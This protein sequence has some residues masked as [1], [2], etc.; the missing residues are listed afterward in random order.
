MSLKD[1]VQK[2]ESELLK[3]YADVLEFDESVFGDLDNKSPLSLNY[4]DG[5][6]NIDV[7]SVAPAS[8]NQGVGR[9]IVNEIIAF[10]NA[11]NLEIRVDSLVDEFF[12]KMG[13]ENFAD[14]QGFVD[15][16]L[17][18]KLPDTKE[19][20]VMQLLDDLKEKYGQFLDDTASEAGDG[21]G[22]HFD[23]TSGNI[24]DGDEI[25]IEAFYLKP[26]A[27][28][29]GIGKK[30]VNAI[31]KLSDEIDVPITLLDK[32]LESPYG[33]SFWKSMDFDIDD[34]TATALY[35]YGG[36]PS[37]T[38]FA[39]E[40]LQLAPDDP[41]E[42]F[43]DPA[44]ENMTGAMESLSAALPEDL[45]DVDLSDEDK[46]MIEDFRKNKKE[47]EAITNPV[48]SLEDDV[49]EITNDFV[50]KKFAEPVDTADGVIMR[51]NDSN[52]LEVLVIKRKRGPHRGDWALPGGIMDSETLKEFDMA[53]EAYMDNNVDSNNKSHVAFGKTP[54]DGDSK[55]RRYTFT[56]LKEIMEEVGLD[57]S[58]PDVVDTLGGM[59]KSLTP[60]Y[61]R[62]DWDARATQGVSVGGAFV[63]VHNNDWQP[64]AGDDALKAEWK[65]VK[66]IVDGDIK[67]AF[68][69]TEWLTQVLGNRKLLRQ[70]GMTKAFSSF[71]TYN[72]MKLENYVG[73]YTETM[74]K[75]HE[76]NIK[77]KSDITELIQ[78]ANKVRVEKGMPEIPVDKSNIQGTAESIIKNLRLNGP[79][80]PELIL[81]NM[82][83]EE[84]INRMLTDKQINYELSIDDYVQDVFIEEVNK[85]KI[86]DEIVTIDDFT[87]PTSNTKLLDVGALDV[88]LNETGIDNVARQIQQQSIKNVEDQLAFLSRQG[89]NDYQI[90]DELRNVYTEKLLTPKFLKLLKQNIRN[91]QNEKRTSYYA[92]SKIDTILDPSVTQPPKVVIR[93][94]NNRNIFSTFILNNEIQ[95]YLKTEKQ[96]NFLSQVFDNQMM[97]LPPAEF[98][99][100]YGEFDETLSQ[101]SAYVQD[102]K[103]YFQ[104]NHGT[105]GPKQGILNLIAYAT[106]RAKDDPRLGDIAPG[107]KQQRPVFFDNTFSFVDPTLGKGGLIGPLLYTT[108]SPFVGAGY[109]TGSADGH[110]TY[111]LNSVIR[112]DIE[113]FV[114][115]NK[116][117]IKFLSELEEVAKQNGIVIDF[118][119]SDDNWTFT[120]LSD[121]NGNNDTTSANVANIRGSVN[122]ENVL[123]INQSTLPGQG[124]N[125]LQSYWE[126]VLDMFGEDWY[127]NDLKNDGGVVKR[128]NFGLKDNIFF[129]SDLGLPEPKT[130][131][132]LKPEIIPYIV[133]ANKVKAIPGAQDVSTLRNWYRW[134][135]TTDPDFFPNIGHIVGTGSNLPRILSGNLQNNINNEVIQKAWKI[136]KNIPGIF[137]NT[138]QYKN[139]IQVLDNNHHY[140]GI[141]DSIDYQ[142]LSNTLKGIVAIREE[143]YI[144]AAKFLAIEF[145]NGEW[146]PVA[147][148]LAT[149]LDEA[150]S[151]LDFSMDYKNNLV[152]DVDKIL[153]KELKLQDNLLISNFNKEFFDTNRVN[154]VNNY[155]EANNL[156]PIA[157]K[158]NVEDILNSIYSY[159]LGDSGI[160][161]DILDRKIYTLAGQ[162][163]YELAL[164]TG[165]GRV[166]SNPH[167][168]LG[169]ID[170][171]NKLQTNMPKTLEVGVKGWAFMNEDDAEHLYRLGSR[172][173]ENLTDE[174]LLVMS[175]YMNPQTIMDLDISEA[176]LENLDKITKE[177]GIYFGT[178]LDNLAP[179]GTTNLSVRHMMLQ[180]ELHKIHT[181]A[182]VGQVPKEAV[183]P[184][185]NSFLKLLSE[186]PE[187]AR[188]Q[189]FMGAPN[190]VDIINKYTKATMRG[191]GTAL[192]YG[193]KAADKFDKYVL[194]PAALDILASRISGPGS[195]YETIGGA[196]ADTINRYEGEEKDT[197]IEMLYGNKNNPE[198]KNIF[199][200]NIAAPVTEGIEYGKDKF[201]EYV[202]DNNIFG[203]KSIVKF[204]KPKVIEELKEVRDKVGLNDWLYKA[205]RDM[206]VEMIMTD[207]NV[208]YTKENINIYTKAYEDNNPREVDK[209]G[210]ELPDNYDNSWAS[211]IPDNR[212]SRDFRVSE[213]IRTGDRYT[214][215]GGGSGVV[216]E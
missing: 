171:S 86:G 195:Q 27:Q 62:L 1:D 107:L 109:A 98:F 20:Q 104:T 58:D 28:G 82:Q 111:S 163:G 133:A 182:E 61:A 78:A 145:L 140:F 203:I 158:D 174:D 68:G 136:D 124:D 167:W 117:N 3:K 88:P 99:Q 6:L 184:I 70:T 97:K 198:V 147:D 50:A 21:S 8:Q 186:L 199:G 59:V 204:L 30:M 155:F 73:D 165:G 137:D 114:N 183:Y 196:V 127:E 34:D 105:P 49:A 40:S 29:K 55:Q 132:K 66:S 89:F 15:E 207:N 197:I 173:L 11:N 151:G 41:S 46:Q 210:N 14:E 121:F 72:P 126:Q 125:K 102:G 123:K 149:E 176:Q 118:V 212:L 159:E 100:K 31:K 142:V 177:K 213:R 193:G 63:F 192:K 106:S 157:T 138:D 103:L 200:V 172:N 216:Q 52:E 202:Y 19:D 93:Y 76:I 81:S 95:D 87:N 71:N 48:N 5:K 152:S 91:A 211:S 60:K 24:I 56:A 37:S 162:N 119:K 189:F 139:V 94:N 90:L 65:T 43:K 214:R 188:A 191:A 92:L 215:G 150:L 25:Y 32:T 148:K 205:K 80:E 131:Y 170:P 9:N 115:S 187:E 44:S 146:V 130:N 26:E 75:L 156:K 18:R 141:A 169:I 135:T 47:F 120:G 33:S 67:L 74:D 79:G 35:N 10:A 175:R 168:V 190:T 129:D 101:K 128:L 180:S 143:N 113:G 2:L 161:S 160:N 16:A 122:I 108:T 84:F 54:A 164:S 4:Y 96:E 209:Y 134:K 116:Y 7:I 154:F 178:S 112:D 77:N 181:L 83:P 201:K 53:E 57:L 39:K 42:L 153:N 45:S 17:F 144:E 64:K 13:F 12:E 185:I 51:I 110:D 179:Q 22:L 38:R 208:P 23:L 194:L 85:Q 206:V 69:H 36:D 166:G